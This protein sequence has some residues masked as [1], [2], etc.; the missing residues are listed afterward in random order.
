VRSPWCSWLREESLESFVAAEPLASMASGIH[1]VCGI[2]AEIQGL[3]SLASLPG[4]H[5]CLVSMAC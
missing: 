4:A 2:P 1:G 3:E 5:G